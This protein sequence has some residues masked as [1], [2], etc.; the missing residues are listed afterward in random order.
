MLSSS[1]CQPPACCRNKLT[2]KMYEVDEVQNDV[3]QDAFENG[4][5]VENS[6]LHPRLGA[7]SVT[8]GTQ[9]RH[10]LR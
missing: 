6:D 3:W 10:C 1:R 7:M 2:R 5:E 8:W 9:G 4:D